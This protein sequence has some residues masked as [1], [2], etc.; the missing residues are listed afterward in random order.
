M[1]ENMIPR[2]LALLE[3]K[4]DE[5]I[6]K[7]DVSITYK[8]DADISEEAIIQGLMEISAMSLPDE[9]HKYYRSH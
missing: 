9:P 8:S 7:K 4:E 3:S 5:L 1:C 2:S 6:Y